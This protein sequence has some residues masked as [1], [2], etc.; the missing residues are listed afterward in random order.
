MVAESTLAATREAL[1][2]E[3]R[4]RGPVGDGVAAFYRESE[5]LGADLDAWHKTPERQEW[6]RTIVEVAG[7]NKV[8]SVLDVG[9]GGGHD[10]LALRDEFPDIELLAIEPNERLRTRLAAA[11]I[12][13]AAADRGVG[14]QFDLVLC[15]DVL[16]H[17]TDPNAMLRQLGERV[18]N[19]G[20][21]IEATATHDQET[22]LHLPELAGWEAG[23]S[24]NR[25]GFEAQEQFGR[26]VVWQKVASAAVAP[27]TVLLCAHREVTVP[28]VE[29]LFELVGRGWPVAMVYGDAL[30][31][32]ARA[33]AA[34]TWYRTAAEDVFL[35]IDDDIV[36]RAEDA[37]RVVELAREKRSIACAAY[38]VGDG[39]HL[40]SRGFPGQ[41]LEFGPDKEP[42]EIRWPAT[43]FMA[44]HR[45]V[46]EALSQTMPVCYPGQPDAFWPM[47]QPF[48]LGPDYLSEDYAFGQRARDLGF[49]TWLDPKTILIHL[50]VKGL[51]V[52][53]MPGAKAR[54]G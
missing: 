22:P 27:A 39:S 53:N 43:G 4:R 28:T 37:E 1:A 33:K 23:P 41:L 15:I 35:M 24:L 29:C 48:A 51:S 13:A 32:R 21:L 38:P 52:L 42:V 10:L 46:I 50:K 11:G 17:V 54:L 19:G 20:L 36:F 47:F 9:A 3:W 5:C 18:R 40:A 7:A 8:Q 12:S 14:G 26:L 16:E 45:D 6:T 44:V 31:D 30:I 34:S 49:P 2:D 25:L